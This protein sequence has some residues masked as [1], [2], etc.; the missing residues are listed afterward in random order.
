MLTEVHIR[1][2]SATGED[3]FY[4]QKQV[5][6]V[7]SIMYEAMVTYTPLHS[8]HGEENAND[9]LDVCLI[10]NVSWKIHETDY[11]EK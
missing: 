7:D 10:L 3:P 6:V 2:P 8:G 11:I 4:A 1:Q 9:P 5:W